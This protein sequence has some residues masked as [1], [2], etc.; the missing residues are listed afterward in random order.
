MHNHHARRNHG[1]RLTAAHGR[2][3][4]IRRL[5]SRLKLAERVGRIW[6]CR[7]AFTLAVCRR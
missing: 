2:L 1:R 6:L 3:W 7:L 5:R 4:R